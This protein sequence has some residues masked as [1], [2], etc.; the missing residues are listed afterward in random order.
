MKPIGSFYPLAGDDAS[1]PAV[2]FAYAVDTPEQK[3]ALHDEAMTRLAAV[4]SL[5]DALLSMQVED[6]DRRSHTRV[7]EAI[8]I[9]SRDVKGL[10]EATGKTLY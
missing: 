4:T 10:I 3:R 1:T 7:I 6:P 2:L 9:L 5:S 8:A